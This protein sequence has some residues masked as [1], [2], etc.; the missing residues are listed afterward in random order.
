MLIYSYNFN[1]LNGLQ[2]EL[3]V[4]QPSDMNSFGLTAGVHIFINNKSVNNLF[5]EG[6]LNEI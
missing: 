6:K 3:Y 5:F 4:G 1:R 2:M